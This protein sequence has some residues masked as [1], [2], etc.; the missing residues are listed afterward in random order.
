MDVGIT[1]DVE[2]FRS[3]FHPSWGSGR[4]NCELALT[5]RVID[6][7]EAKRIGLVSVC[8]DVEARAM[9]L[10]MMLASKSPLAVRWH[11][12]SVARHERRAGRR[13]RVEL[14]RHA[15]RGDVNER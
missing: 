8:E 15:Q 14:R 6:A 2:R 13:E 3:G 11:E 5:A 7:E 9:A 10:A 12:E 1:A 4:A